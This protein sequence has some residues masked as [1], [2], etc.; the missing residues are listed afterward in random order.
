[1][2]APRLSEFRFTESQWDAI[3]IELERMGRLKDE[4]DR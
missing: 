2:D 1:M 3:G 4:G